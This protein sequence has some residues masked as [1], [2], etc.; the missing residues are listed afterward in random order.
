[1]PFRLRQ[2]GLSALGHQVEP[3]A[4][5]SPRVTILGRRL[6]VDG[7]AYLNRSV[8]IDAT[9]PITIE[10]GVHIGPNVQI[11]TGTHQVGD[12][13]QRAGANQALPIT[14]GAGSWIGAGAILVAG[15]TVG[16]GCIVGAGAVVT[17]DCERDGLY[18]GVPARRVRDL[19]E[20]TPV[21]RKPSLLSSQAAPWSGSRS[22]VSP[23]RSSR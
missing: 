5:I 6:K 3:G 19:S 18:A 15:V 22:A 12:D 20:P 4:R 16:A 9:A 17:A 10:S 2:A 21:R 8:L 1:M 7:S 11:L 23:P 14:I 13:V